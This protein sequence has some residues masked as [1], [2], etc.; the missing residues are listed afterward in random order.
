MAEPSGGPP[1][2]QDGPLFQS[3][4]RR[5]RANRRSPW[6]IVAGVAILVLLGFGGWYWFRGRD[7]GKTGPVAE[8]PAPVD[9]AGAG[10]ESMVPA[11]DLP[12]LDQSD[13]FLRPLLAQLSDHPGWARWLLPE[14]LA[15]R[16]VTSVVNVAGGE[17]PRSHLEFLAPADSFRARASGDGF[18][19]DS[20]SYRRYD[21]LT[22]T[23]LSLDTRSAAR[24][25]R[26][27]HPLFEEAHT[28]LG[29]ANRS[30][31]GS[32]ALAVGNIL[33]VQVPEDAVA[34]VPAG[35]VYE[36][37]D[38]DLEALTPAEKHVLRLGPRNARRIQAKLSDLTSRL[39]ITPG[40]PDAR[41]TPA[42][43]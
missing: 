1:R 12:E 18:V 19:I 30:F 31:D 34:V 3:R 4:R 15:R 36:L 11:L 28:E 23:F 43:R 29:L 10:D 6:K 5:H 13:E 8:A 24:L 7:A 35:A 20:A 25:Y 42:T 17:S 21:A 26:Q 9:T 16:F 22:E 38:P 33:A 37:A 39:G 27:L 40:D 14:D 32:F 2:P 41:V